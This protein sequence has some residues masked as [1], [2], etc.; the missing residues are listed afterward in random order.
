M[1]FALFS[2]GRSLICGGWRVGDGTACLSGLA[3][4]AGFAHPFR[5]QESIAKPRT[6]FLVGDCLRSFP[7]PSPFLPS[8]VLDNL[9]MR[10]R[11]VWREGRE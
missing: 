1:E 6:C 4:E 11:R 10:K 7:L 2:A 5:A 8:A 9:R 3:G